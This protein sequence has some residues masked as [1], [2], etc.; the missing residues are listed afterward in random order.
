MGSLINITTKVL[1]SDTY[2]ERKVLA[3]DINQFKGALQSGT[4]D[5]KPDDIAME[6]NTITADAGSN[7]IRRNNNT[8][9]FYDGAWKEPTAIEIG[10]FTAGEA[11]AIRD[12]VY[13]N[14]A[15]NKIYICDVDDTTKTDWIGVAKAAISNAAT[16]DVYLNNSLVGGFTGLTPGDW[17]GLSSTAGD[18]TATDSYVVGIA[19]TATQIKLIK[20]KSESKSVN[21]TWKMM[22]EFLANGVDATYSQEL[23][24]SNLKIV[25]KFLDSTGQNNTV[26]TIYA[27]TT[28]SY[29]IASDYYVCKQTATGGDLAQTYQAVAATGAQ[30]GKCGHKILANVDCIL[31]SITKDAASTATIGY[32]L[33]SDE[34]VI[35][36]KTFST[37][38]AT[39]DTPVYLTTGT[40]YY[41]CADKGGASY[42]NVYNQP[43]TFPI[44]NTETSST[45]GFFND[46]ESSDI[47]NNIESAVVKAVT[48][49]YVDGVVQSNTTTIPTTD[50]K[51]MF[52]PLMYEALAGSDALTFD[53][54][55][56]NEAN[57]E[58]GNAL[59][60]W[61]DASGATNTGTLSVRL[62]FDTDDGSTTPKVKGWSI[63]TDD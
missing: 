44:N 60:T 25:D 59:N 4:Y 46:A 6:G 9:E 33:D 40:Y 8:F 52:V 62:Q 53:Y 19:T 1:N 5:I 12:V 39:F 48:A 49:T 29:N 35:A 13:L 21:A 11:I 34:N 14:T 23:V 47:S 57:W 42:T 61:I 38:T 27:N 51:I 30:T 50:D 36:S 24:S 18:I 55:M 16:G 15:D 28:A 32:I 45:Y 37:N 41:L 31:Y 2:N 43:T 58:T 63:F 17:Y 56:D 54:S 20:P 7:W 26:D 10:S 22:G 3:T